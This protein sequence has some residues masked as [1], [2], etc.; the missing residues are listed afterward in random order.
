MSNEEKARK[1]NWHQA[2][3]EVALII[4][5]ILFALAV[6]SWWE[7][8]SER[9]AEIDYLQSLRA[10]FVYIRDALSEEI[11]WEKNRINNGKEI[12]A[13]IAS[14]LTRLAPEDFIQTISARIQVLIVTC[15]AERY[16]GIGRALTLKKGKDTA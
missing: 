13:N 3:A 8:R 10:D 14:G 4:L 16:R 12:H 6:D 1:V 11:E 15:H 5:G 9:E 7:D 2:I